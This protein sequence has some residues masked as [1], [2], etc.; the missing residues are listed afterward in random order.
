[1]H[2]PSFGWTAP[3]TSA[4]SGLV[5]GLVAIM[6]LASGAAPRVVACLDLALIGGVLGIGWLLEAS[7]NGLSTL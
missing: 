1:M 6:S 5:S 2:I 3:E 4:S 7:R